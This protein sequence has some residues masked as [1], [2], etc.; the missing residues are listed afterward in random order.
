MDLTRKPLF[1]LPTSLPA[2]IAPGRQTASNTPASAVST[3]QQAQRE[4]EVAQGAKDSTSHTGDFIQTKG[5]PI[6][7]EPSTDNKVARWNQAFSQGGDYI[8][9]GTG[10]VHS[11]KDMGFLMTEGTL[12][13]LQSA[14]LN[15]GCGWSMAPANPAPKGQVNNA[16]RVIQTQGE[17][18]TY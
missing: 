9:T 16:K 12:R 7:V 11:I 15:A 6:Y 1:Q 14:H 5:G 18:P 8:V 17:H 10:Q 4:L 2:S 13:G 3:A